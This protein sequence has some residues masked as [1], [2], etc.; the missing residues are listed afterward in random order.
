MKKNSFLFFFLF[1]FLLISVTEAQQVPLS[2][3]V[4]QPQQ[5]QTLKIAFFTP[6]YLDSAFDAGYTYKFGK[7][8]PKFLNP[9]L[10]FYQ[11]AQM[12]L[13][14]L[15]KAG[16]PLEVFIYDSRSKTN[17]FNRQITRPEVT[18]ADMIIAHASAV[19]VRPLA[20]LAKQNNIP[21]ISA[22]F[23]NDAGI[24]NN[25]YYVMLNPTLKTHV[26]SL[27]RYLQRNHAKDRVIVFRKNGAQ[28]DQIRSYLR[29]LSSNANNSLKLEFRD[30]GNDFTNFTLSQG[31][32][33][34]RRT[35]AIAGSLDENFGNKL[36]QQLSALGTS[37]P[38]TLI[39]MPTWDNLN[40][41]KPEIKNIEVVYSTPFNFNAPSALNT[42]LTNEYVNNVNSRP[43]DMFYRGYETMLRFALLLL[44]TKK[45]VSSNLTRKGN[46]IFTQYEIQP[47]FINKENPTLDYFE[48]KKLYYVR[49]VNGVKSLN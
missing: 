26:E 27:Y 12:A 33:T 1:N 21:F 15:N 5:V 7:N 45:D 18:S 48:N 23:P 40:L 10:E 38:I 9:G 8:F 19:D 16:A 46:Y 41:S 35:V 28:E 25:P 4:Q 24:V 2:E 17:P 39:G 47:V 37:N 11:G 6:L 42:K 34:L 30:I 13:D 31:M 32:D 20:D 36:V 43:T 14:S 49:V 3:Q 29:E 44:D 22:T